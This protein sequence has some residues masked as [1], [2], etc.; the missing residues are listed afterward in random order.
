MD[1]IIKFLVLQ[2]IYV[3]HFSLIESILF[4]L[5][6]IQTAADIHNTSSLYETHVIE[7]KKDMI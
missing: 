6:I 3:S 7:I 5:N 2:D 4:V 1:L